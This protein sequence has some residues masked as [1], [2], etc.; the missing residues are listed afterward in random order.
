MQAGD[1]PH[2]VAIPVGTARTAPRTKK[3]TVLDSV[4]EYHSILTDKK[5]QPL[6]TFITKWG[7]FMYL[8]MPQGY[9][10]SGDAYICRYDKIIKDT[11]C[12]VKI[13]DDTLLYDSSIKGAFYHI[14]DFLLQCAKNRIVLN[15]YKFQ[16]C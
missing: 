9:L 3:K 2:W 5:S 12:K 16:L 7:R 13:V 14:F 15:T 11:T 8:R 1:S 10:A 4:N 6:T